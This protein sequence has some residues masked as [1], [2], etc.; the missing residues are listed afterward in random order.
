MG[1]VDSMDSPGK[2]HGNDYSR[3]NRLTVVAV[4]RILSVRIK[5]TRFTRVLSTGD[6]A[7]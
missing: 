1:L 5:V 7:S 4:P 2:L 3:L 6:L